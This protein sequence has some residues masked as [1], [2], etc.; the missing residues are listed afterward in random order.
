ML[1]SS[2]LFL[3]VVGCCLSAV[4]L[5]DVDCSKRPPFVNP[6]TCCPM[7]EFITSELKEKCA[8]YNT[9]QPPPTDGDASGSFEG[10]RRHHHPHPPPC[11]FSCIFNETGIYMNKK[12]DQDKLKSYLQVVFKDS[13]DLQS[14]ATEAFTTCATKVV[15]FEAN[16][17]ARPRPSPPP[18]MPMCP[19]D[20]GHLMGCVFRNLMKNCPAS[21]RN[22]SAECTEARDFF[23]NCKPPRG[24]PPS[25]EQM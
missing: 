9:T 12:L 3:L 21:I 18:G 23:T 19:H 14:V 20:A 7:P 4:A 22:D 17:P 1:S 8:Q 6:K 10:R 11:L 5:A 13:T 16:L 15:D 24:P 25:A 2:Q